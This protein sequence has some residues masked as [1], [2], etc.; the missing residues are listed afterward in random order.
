M[1]IDTGLLRNVLMESCEEYILEYSLIQRII[2]RSAFSVAFVKN[3][4]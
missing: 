1:R 4:R 2:Q 3:V